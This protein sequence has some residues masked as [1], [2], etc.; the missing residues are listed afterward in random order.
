MLYM[1]VFVLKNA[2]IPFDYIYTGSVLVGPCNLCQFTQCKQVIFQLE[3]LCAKLLWY[4][5]QI[6]CLQRVSQWN[7]VMPCKAVKGFKSESAFPTR[8]LPHKG[9]CWAC[10]HWRWDQIDDAMRKKN[11]HA[12]DCVFNKRLNKHIYI[13][14]CVFTYIYMYIY[15]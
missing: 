2:S 9:L 11:C 12:L 15:I 8:P 13:Y 7:H 5:C 3:W 10:W 6:L 1:I 4:S 14:S